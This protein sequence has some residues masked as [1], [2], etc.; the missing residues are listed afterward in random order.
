M[1]KPQS[2]IVLV[3]RMNQRLRVPDF[4]SP[5]ASAQPTLPAGYS[6]ATHELHSMTIFLNIPPIPTPTK[7]LQA[8]RMLNIPVALPW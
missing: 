5:L 7:N 8:V 3:K 6:P 4:M 1:T 2:I